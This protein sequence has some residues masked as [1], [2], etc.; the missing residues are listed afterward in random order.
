LKE[1]FTRILVAIVGIPIVL[2]SIIFGRFYFVAFVTLVALIG[3]YELFQ[4]VKR[5][6]I[7][8]HQFLGYIGLASITILIFYQKTDLIL[9]TLLFVALISLGL[10]MFRLGEKPILNVAATLFG[11]IYI[12]LAF[13]SLIGVRESQI[14]S[15]YNAVGHLVIALFI[16]VWICDT[17]AY[18]FGTRFGKHRLYEQVSPKKSVEGAVAGFIGVLLFY[19]IVLQSKYLPEMSVQMAIILALVVGIFGQ[20]GDLVESWLKRTI[21]IK[22]S[23]AIIPGHGGVL[24]RF[25]S[26]L[27]V[28]PLT[29]I[30]IQFHLM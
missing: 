9:V 3:L 25:D 19:F 28:A 27:F 15:G 12:G 2:A 18:F 4:M 30:A 7:T 10:E 5:Q 16:G 20:I 11:L 6:G 21:Q 13:G 26:M 17:I 14:F 23:S 29:Y 22:D 24:D 8:P 1:L